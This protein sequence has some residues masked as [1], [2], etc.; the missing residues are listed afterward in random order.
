[1]L[2][3]T[4]MIFGMPGLAI[5][6]LLHITVIFLTNTRL[7]GFQTNGFYMLIHKGF[8]RNHLTEI[9]ISF[10]PLLSHIIAFIL[11]FYT[12]YAILILAYLV[13]YAS[14]SS[15]DLCN[16]WFYKKKKKLYKL[17]SEL[18]EEVIDDNISRGIIKTNLFEAIYG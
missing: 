13:I 6:E 4:H 2:H 18:E 12:P 15:R 17:Y 1:M 11:C 16:V 9:L 3:K 8:S 14:P 5:H 10:A 7:I